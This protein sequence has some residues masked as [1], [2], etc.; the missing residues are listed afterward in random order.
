MLLL[1][2]VYCVP[3]RESSVPGGLTL[4]HGPHSSPVICQDYLLFLGSVT[5]TQS[6][7][8]AAQHTELVSD[9]AQVLYSPSESTYTPPC[10]GGNSELQADG[11]SRNS[12]VLLSLYT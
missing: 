7:E 11:Y 10:L 2:R 9:R 8:Q 6:T 3:G 12:E 1:L 4:S 5:E